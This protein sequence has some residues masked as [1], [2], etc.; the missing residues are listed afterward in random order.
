MNKPSGFTSYSHKD[1]EW[2][3]DYLLTN[4]EKNGIACH[5]DYRDFEIGKHSLYNFY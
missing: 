1:K 4:L 5:L 3:T 2:V